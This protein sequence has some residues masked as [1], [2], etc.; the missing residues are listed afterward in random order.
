[1][2]A[3]LAGTKTATASLLSDY[4]P[5]TGDPLPSVGERL[6]LV[7]DLDRPVAIVETTELRVVLAGQVDLQFALDEGEGF[8][9]VSEW[10]AAHERFW[11]DQAITDETHIVCQRIRLIQ[12]L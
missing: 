10:R 7:D 11:S 3:V 8:E 5:A 2:A 1:V 9:T 6:V 12:T 4:A